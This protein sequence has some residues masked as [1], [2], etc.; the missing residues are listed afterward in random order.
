MDYILA[1][2]IGTTNCK[3]VTFDRNLQ[4]IHSIKNSYQTITDDSGKSEQNPDEVFAVIVQL[5]Q[6]SLQKN[7]NIKAVSFSAAMHSVVAVDAEGK[8]LT[9][10]ILWSD[11]RATK[12]AEK[13]KQS[14]AGTIIYIKTGTPIHPMSPLC[15]IIWLKET[16]PS[17][18]NNTYKFISIKEYV[19]LKLFGK[20]IVDYSVASATGLFDITK[21]NWCEEAL[22]AAAITVD[23]LSQPV[24]AT[25][26]ESDLLPEYK[27]LFSSK[28][29]IPFIVGGND[30]CLANLGSGVISAGDASLTIGT[31]GAIRMTTNKR[32]PDVAQRIFTYL[33]TKDIYISGGAINNGGITLE[34]LSKTILNDA[35]PKEPDEVLRLAAT[36]PAGADRL[37]FLPYLLGERAP[38]WDAA[39]KGVL[40]GLTQ[41]HTKAH[42]ARATVEGIC[43]AL[44]DVMHATEETNGTINRIYASGGFTQS[45]FWLQVMADVLGKEII[46]NN[47]ADASATGAAMIGMNA[48]GWINDLSATAH[49]FTPQQTF[50]PDVS[51]HK[52]Y[53]SLFLIFQSLYSK[54]K[55]SFV[56]ISN[57]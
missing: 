40:F 31:S 55:D 54:L 25:H 35:T 20:Y 37:L 9:N 43:F 32:Q 30:G 49:F 11:T 56:A 10:A 2:D 29:I 22:Q 39:A 34:W 14:E 27:S 17:V 19:F 46:I 7:D 21:T 4:T 44:R 3:A 1:I 48:L 57:L 5:I 6:Q 15:K 36:V 41:Q 24:E 53:T 26:R 23:R 50:S 28:Q 47:S 51:L 33:L 8:P 16:M 18:F 13:L 42:I 38:M 52:T 12:Q 45:S